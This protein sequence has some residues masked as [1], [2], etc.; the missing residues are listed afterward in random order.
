MRLS[1]QL[2]MA[3]HPVPPDQDGLLVKLMRLSNAAY[4][5]RE[6]NGVLPLV[7]IGHEALGEADW[8]RWV[9]ENAVAAYGPAQAERYAKGGI[10]LKEM[11][12]TAG[13]GRAMAEAERASN[14][15]SGRR[16]M[17]RAHGGLGSLQGIVVMVEKWPSL[18]NQIAEECAEEE[19]TL[20]EFVDRVWAMPAP[21]GIGGRQYTTLGDLLGR[22]IHVLPRV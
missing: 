19:M 18:Y 2:Q 5:G 15:A 12:P 4:P 3:V 1:E 22:S 11:L 20:K 9:R 7:V 16:F 17:L 13:F 6:A 8:R 14:Q 10:D 21:Q